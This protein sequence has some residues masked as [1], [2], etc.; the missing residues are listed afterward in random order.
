MFL[1]ELIHLIP[2]AV[3]QIFISSIG[4]HCHKKLKKRQKLPK[5]FDFSAAKLSKQNEG[6]SENQ[7]FAVLRVLRPVQTQR[8]AQMATTGSI[9]VI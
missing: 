8:P 9:V 5:D 7:L 1:N 3:L 6:Y 2:A 4:N